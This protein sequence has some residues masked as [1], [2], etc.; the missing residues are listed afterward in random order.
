MQTRTSVPSTSVP[1]PRAASMFWQTWTSNV[2]VRR[3]WDRLGVGTTIFQWVAV[4]GSSFIPNPWLP[5]HGSQLDLAD[6]ATR[7]W[8]RRM[9]IGTPGLSD[10]T[11]ARAR[12]HELADLAQKFGTLSY[13]SNAAGFYFPVEID[14][15]YTAAP[16]DFGA[17]WSK[18]PRPLYVSV[19]YGAGVDDAAA[20]QWLDSFIP[21]DV[22]ILFQ[23]GVGAHGAT[24]QQALARFDLIR[25]RH[26]KTEMIAEAFR[27]NPTPGGAYF[28]PATAAEYQAQ[29]QAYAHLDPVHVF[30]GPNYLDAALIQ[31]IGGV[32]PALPPTA[33]NARVNSWG[34]A[35]L[36]WQRASAASV[37]VAK[38]RVEI[39]DGMGA[40]VLRRY[41]VP[42]GQAHCFYPVD[43][44]VADF[45]FP[46]AYLA[47]RVTEVAAN[48]YESDPSALSAGMAVQD[49]SW[50]Q[51]VVGMAGT[52]YTGGYFSDLSDQGN[53]GTTGVAGRK[54]S[55]AAATLRRAMAQ[56]AGLHIAQILPVNLTV[57]GSHLSRTSADLLNSTSYWWDDTQSAPGPNLLAIQ[58]RI[59]ALGVPLTHMMWSGGVEPDTIFQYP[60]QRDAILAAAATALPAIHATVRG[61]GG[62]PQLKLWLQPHLRA[63]YGIPPREGTALQYKAVRDALVNVARAD[64][65]IYVGT[66]V[67]GAAFAYDYWN[68]MPQIG[69]VHPV[70]SAYHAAAEEM[71]RMMAL[72]GDLADAP[73]A[74]AT[75]A[76][77]SAPTVQ[78][79]PS[80]DVSVRWNP[81]QSGTGWF[82]VRNLHLGTGAVIDQLDTP[83]SQYLFTRA[84]QVATYGYTTAGV[85]LDICEF[86]PAS[87][88][89]GP[90]LSITQYKS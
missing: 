15:T 41:E 3:Q 22:T 73:P 86:D 8:A 17:I 78:W 77:P 4:N 64:P 85:S 35:R 55:V 59:A 29:L 30:D 75:M 74:W 33:L 60:A 81:P 16:A 5:L 50:A 11:Q 28:I 9:I 80:E 79:Q 45:G 58:P 46:P 71:G 48:G 23:D 26:P 68:E 84:K 54:S 25:A 18:L 47:W 21:Q 42:G 61:Y 53:P 66:W 49:N 43:D 52:S 27:P 31:R 62:N 51:A 70:P 89:E 1:A 57:G 36:D 6:I 76:P 14:P 88:A 63:Y 83:S 10:E 38:Y 65:A 87:G 37:A 7:P 44:S 90:V 72:D 13:P 34:D 20:A 19:Y 32:E 56:A 12:I 69:W 2:D 67:P 40:Q 39:L 24:P 82:R